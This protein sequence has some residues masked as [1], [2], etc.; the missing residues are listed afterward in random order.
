MRVINLTDLG[1]SYADIE[2]AAGGRRRRLKGR[3]NAYQRMG[4]SYRPA[5]TDWVYLNGIN[6]WEAWNHLSAHLGYCIC[7]VC[8]DEDLRYNAYCLACDR[9]GGDEAIGHK[10]DGADVGSRLRLDVPVAYIEQPKYAGTGKVKGG[11]GG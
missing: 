3:R 8:G 5:D 2:G 11:K 9:T 4:P 7:P 1:A 6:P 10:F